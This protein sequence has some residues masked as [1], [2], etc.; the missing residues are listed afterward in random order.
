MQANDGRGSFGPVLV[1][2]AVISFLSVAACVA[3]RVCGGRGSSRSPDHQ[4]KRGGEAE[5]GLGASHV[6]VVMRP[7]PSSRASVHDDAFEV[8]LLPPNRP[9][10]TAGTR[11]QERPA[12]LPQQFTAAAGPPS[13]N[14]GVVQPARHPPPAL[15]SGVAVLPAER[16]K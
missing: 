6:A 11:A 13:G 7:V 3:G 10:E 12:G 16:S 9:R 2:L 4:Q 5:K 14:G 8:K 15:R 1:V